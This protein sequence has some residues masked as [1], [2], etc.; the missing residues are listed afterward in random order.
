MRS[1]IVT[2]WLLFGFS[3]ITLQFVQGQSLDSP[4][5]DPRIKLGGSLI[6]TQNY[7]SRRF[8][9]EG[10]KSYSCPTEL[11]EIGSGYGF[12]LSVE[13]LPCV[14]GSWGILPRVSFERRPGEGVVA[15]DGVTY[16]SLITYDLLN[17]EIMYKQEVLTYGDVRFGVLSG[18]SFQYITQA[19]AKVLETSETGITPRCFDEDDAYINTSRLSIKGGVQGE[20]RLFDDQWMIVPGLFLDY[21][22]TG[23]SRS[24]KGGMN[25]LIFQVD[26]RKAL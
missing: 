21:R 9:T 8:K 4:V 1:Y 25:S 17:A 22:L 5:C 13:F 10:T 15:A 6:L 24:T 23:F 18:P 19:T 26:F 14:D 2:I 11:S 3:V 16:H 7:H 12:G 20:V